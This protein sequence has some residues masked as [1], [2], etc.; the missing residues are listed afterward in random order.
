L[1]KWLRF[2]PQAGGA[3]IRDKDA[4]SEFWL[5]AALEGFRDTRTQGEE[6][7]ASLYLSYCR[8]DVRVVKEDTCCGS[9]C[10]KWKREYS[11]T[12]E[13]NSPTRRIPERQPGTPRLPRTLAG[14]V[15]AA[16]ASR[17]LTT[18]TPSLIIPALKSHYD[19]LQRASPR[20]RTRVGEEHAAP[21]DLPDL[22]VPHDWPHYTS[23]L[24][25]LDLYAFMANP[26]IV[27]D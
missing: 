25:R 17:Y 1:C 11:V 26:K 10:I 18:G 21:A 13:W 15:G 9:R 20:Y 22:S 16:V 6:C 14:G 4:R 24:E 23:W 3:Q 12:M 8:T 19:E 7:R 5:G 2:H 27:G